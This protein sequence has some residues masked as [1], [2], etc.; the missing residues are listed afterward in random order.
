[1]NGYYFKQT[2]LMLI[3][4]T[5]GILLADS[6]MP[7]LITRYRDT[8]ESVHHTKFGDGPIVPLITKE[9]LIALGKRP[10]LERFR[11]QPFLYLL[12]ACVGMILGL[13]LARITGK[14]HFA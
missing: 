1:M 10:P 8:I 11:S 14:P 4:I 9:Q 12:P 3:G 7:R 6:F 5:V 13:L 2:V